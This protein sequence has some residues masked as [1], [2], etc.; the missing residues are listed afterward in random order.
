MPE[1]IGSRW[2]DGSGSGVFG[3]IRVKGLGLVSPTV[4]LSLVYRFP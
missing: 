2:Y 3:A 4:W 1:N